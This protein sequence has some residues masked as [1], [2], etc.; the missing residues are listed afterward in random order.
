MKKMFIKILMLILF[1]AVVP[2]VVYTGCSDGENS[3]VSGKQVY[4][5][6]MHPEVQS[7][8]PGVC[9]ICH[10]DLV[11]KDQ[12]G[13]DMAEHTDNRLQLSNRKLSLANVSTTSVKK[14][15][16][17]QELSVY[18]YIDFAEDNRKIITA[19]FSG[20]IEKL[21]VNKTGEVIK[22]GQKLFEIYSP[23]LIQAQNDYLIA[24]GGLGNISG[25]GNK[26]QDNSMLNASRQKLLIMGLTESQ[27]N[28]LEQKKE[29]NMSIPYYSPF[30]GTVIEKKVQEGMYV[31][32]GTVIFDI[33][34]LSELWSISEIFSDNLGT[35]K[36][37]DKIK[38]RMQS[39]PGKEFDGTVDFI[40]PVV[41]SETRTIKV[42]SVI[43]NSSGLLKPNM[44]GEAVFSS[45]LGTGLSVPAE[46]VIFTGKRTLVWVEAEK[47]KFE[48]RDIKTGAKINGSY[49]VVSGLK[50]GERVA[51]EGAY[52][53]DSESQLRSGSVQDHQQHG[54]ETP[55]KENQDKQTDSPEH[56]SH[57]SLIFNQ[58]CPV[59][60]NKVS[61][62]APVVEYKG[63]KIG[64]CCPG[65][66]TEFLEE[67][68]K[69]MKNL[70][71]DGKKFITNS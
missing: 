47:G 10:M 17:L 39:Y 54:T 6:P 46:A 70:S 59:L 49:Q 52:L 50:E 23:D 19:K 57:S 51:S 58:V 65:C 62:N 5:C 25:S 42:R 63:K 35:V 71:A 41:N 4:Y 66:D 21:F 13:D 68:E 53:I 43:Q 24:L 30:S 40:Y 12:D 69:Y 29:V 3:G 11:L 28:E 31:N 14:E 56:D 16:L 15:K 27:V 48:P 22:K 44:F 61:E 18:S 64:F 37:G 45:N 55:E 36:K 67:P 26:S 1:F 60:G 9:P 34:D 2:S 20:R 7:N 32:E 33:A 8:K 38:L